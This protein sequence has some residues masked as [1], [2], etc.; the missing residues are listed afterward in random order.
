MKL[1]GM[2]VA[3]AN[4]RLA[5]SWT[6]AETK[7]G[8]EVVLVSECVGLNIENDSGY[9]DC[10]IQSLYGYWGTDGV[11]EQRAV[12]AFEMDAPALGYVNTNDGV[13]HVF[14]VPERQTRAALPQHSV[15][16]SHTP[17]RGAN[18]LDHLEYQHSYEIAC[19]VFLGSE[20]RAWDLEEDGAISPE[21]AYMG[22]VLYGPGWFEI[23]AVQKEQEQLVLS[24]KHPIIAQKLLGPV[25]GGMYASG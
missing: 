9:Y 19:L 5:G 8:C 6:L 17:G 11:R 24:T 10:V 4:L 15:M 22:G 14:R 25:L 7:N 18:R 23:G 2:S 3:D 20:F 21:V 16:V 1:H 12:E 13:Q